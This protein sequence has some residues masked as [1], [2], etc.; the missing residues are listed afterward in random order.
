MGEGPRP[1]S[2]PAA[3]QAAASAGGGPLLGLLA[4]GLELWLRQQCQAIEDLQIQL[5]GS[6][7]QLM[8]GRLEGVRLLARGVVFQDLEI[9]RV[10]LRSDPLQ[11]RMGALVRS[12]GLRLEH[13]FRIEGMVAFSADGLSRTLST[14]PWSELGDQLAEELLGLTPLAGLRFDGE[15]LVLRSPAHDR[16]RP[17]EL[18]TRLLIEA[19]GLTLQADPQ[20]RS[21][22]AEPAQVPPKRARL[23]RD[24][25]IQFQ[26]AEMGG[27]LLE[28]HGEARVSP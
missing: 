19:G 15:H 26:R 5:E 8:R 22:G 23:P 20:P 11:V 9:E 10:E 27:G 12:Q 25:N 16:G 18:P 24:A 13:P 1:D 3:A 14:P 4:R 28:L 21:G 2:E 7:V 6:A 17:V